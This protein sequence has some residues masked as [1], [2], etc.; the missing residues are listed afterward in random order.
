M[1]AAILDGGA[2]GG[3]HWSVCTQTF[4]E[5]REDVV[6]CLGL[7][8]GTTFCQLVNTVQ[9]GKCSISVFGIGIFARSVK[10]VA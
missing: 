3:T 8:G 7:K 4:Y 2:T 9:W 6:C 1:Q 10:D 5:N